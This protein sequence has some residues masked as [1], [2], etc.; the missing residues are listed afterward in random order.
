METYEFDVAIIGGGPAGCTCALYTSRADFKTVI[1]DKNPAVGALAITHKIANYPGVTGNMSGDELLRMMR[2]Q[3]EA[4]GT[5]YQRAQ[6]FGIDVSDT[7]KK[8]YT[9]EGTFVCRAL[10]LAT[11]AMGRVASFKGESEFLGRGVSYCATCD[12]AFYREREVAV[13]GNNH[14]AVEEA[15]FLTK[16]ASTVH[17]ITVKDPQPEDVAAQDLLTLPQIKHWSRTRLMLVEGDQAGVTRVQVKQ[18]GQPE[19]QA[20]PVEGVFIY[21]SG[22]KPIVDFVSDQIAFNPDGGVKV[23]ETM[24]TNVEGVWAI[25]DIRNTPYKQAV[26]AAGDGCIA[27]M[28]IDRFL[29]SRKSIRP[30]WDHS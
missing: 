23:D 3:A 28:S 25:G 9:P 7:L 20:L 14:E 26:V 10:V 18:K 16:F 30:D 17:W 1:L 15:Q 29:N 5:T 4:F 2:E 27:A 22:S 11:G 12:G 8:V 24:S 6:V 19:S 21:Q 13:V